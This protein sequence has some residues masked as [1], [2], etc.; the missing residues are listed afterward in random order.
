M[1]VIILGTFFHR[2]LHN[3]IKKWPNSALSGERELRRLTFEMFELFQVYR[4]CSGF[5][6][7]LNKVNDLEYHF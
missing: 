4:M 3:N 6:F 7:V 1:R 2:P 5:S